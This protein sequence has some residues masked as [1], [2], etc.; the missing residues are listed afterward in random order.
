M[1]RVREHWQDLYGAKA[2]EQTSWFRPRLDAS[3]QL[4]LAHAPDREA[5]VIDVGGG[6][7]TL[8]DDLL[9]QGY[10]DVTVLDVA[11][12]ALEQTRI[13]L[14]SSADDAVAGAF[15]RGAARFLETELLDADLPAAHYGLWHDRAVFHFFT[16]R[17]EQEAYVA[18]ATRSLRPGGIA[19]LAT[20]APDGP[21]T[22]S[23]LPVQRYDAAALGARFGAAFE[24]VA[25]AREL[26]AT[27]FGS[28]Q[29]FT[30]VVLRR[31]AGDAAAAAALPNTP[32]P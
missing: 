22:C 8:V 10:R 28:T 30:Y 32:G 2:P 24:P 9:A 12:A 13:R 31:R 16:D 27:P 19:I 29:P 7:S 14:E 17:S 15:E 25:D 23:G 20:F 21:E 1:A 18:L 3:L 6:R 11:G 5:P 26:H 4:V